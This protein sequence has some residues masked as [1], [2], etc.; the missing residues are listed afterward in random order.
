MPMRTNVSR[1]TLCGSCKGFSLV[2]LMVSILLGSLLSMGMANI[3]LESKRN[4]EAESE[5]AQIQESGRFSLNLLKRELMMAGFYAGMPSV[6]GLAA[7]PVA[8]DCAGT[9][10]AL[11]TSVPID[12][13]NEYSLSMV[14]VNG[15]ELTCLS[16]SEV[17]PGTDIFS[18]KRTAGDPTL[19]NGVY[20]PGVKGA[21]QTQWYLRIQNYQDLP[22]WLYVDAGGF[23]SG[24]IGVGS[25]INYWEMY[26][27]VFYIRNY[28][29][30]MSDGVPALCVERLN[31]S[32]MATRCLVEAVEDMQIEFG[33]DTDS[34]GVPNQFK[35]APTASEMG[36]A[37]VA[38]IFLLIRSV[39]EL[40]GYTNTMAYRLGQKKVKARGDG[41]L[42]RVF[43][44]TV[45]M[46]NATLPV[47]Q[48]REGVANET[49]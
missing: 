24:D 39:N 30:A 15:T 32:A 5:A 2:E 10:W 21:E 34:D 8:V 11:D 44:A 35:Q 37:V 46:R 25:K 31:G 41:F 4:F 16:A 22:S 26:A 45:Q 43:S 20:H 27:R 28:S 23:D 29:N 36:N 49:S 48:R 14:T 42:R 6:A 3:Y 9:T 40:T 19:E 12:L 47:H 33:I 7:S 13:I 18:V 1:H 17:K 38:R